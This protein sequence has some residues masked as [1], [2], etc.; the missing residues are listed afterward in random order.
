MILYEWVASRGSSRDGAL[1][2][3]RSG[4]AAAQRAQLDG[5]TMLLEQVDSVDDLP[6]LIVGPIKVKGQKKPHIYKLQVGRRVS[7]RPLLCK[8]PV[9]TDDHARVL[10]FLIGATERDRKF[11]PR[12]APD[13]AVERRDGLLNGRDRRRRYETPPKR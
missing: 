9:P 13:K 1:T 4:L 2:K 6:G 10:T 3:F 7:L 11:S 5:K 12:N 8:G